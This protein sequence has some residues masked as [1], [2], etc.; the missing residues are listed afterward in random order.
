[1][2]RDAV[3]KKARFKCPILGC[4][5]LKIRIPKIKGGHDELDDG[6]SNGPF[7]EKAELG[8]YNIPIAEMIIAAQLH[9]TFSLILG[10]VVW[11]SGFNYPFNTF[12][13]EFGDEYK[14]Q[15]TS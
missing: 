7:W 6:G 15:T 10:G 2:E 8:G 13:A 3:N 5:K 4:W 11:Q 14:M 12:M 1:M 9:P